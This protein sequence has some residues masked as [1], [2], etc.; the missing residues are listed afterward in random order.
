VDTAGNL[1]QYSANL[2]RVFDS[3]LAHLYHWLIIDE[4]MV[5]PNPE[6]VTPTGNG[7]FQPQVDDWQEEEGTM[8]L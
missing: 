8:V 3:E 1:L 4:T 5:I 6:P 2:D 7:G